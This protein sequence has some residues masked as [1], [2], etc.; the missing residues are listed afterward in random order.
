MVLVPA[1]S[2]SPLS[3]KEQDPYITVLSCWTN[4]EE[5]ESES[6]NE[7]EDKG[8][9]SAASGSDVSVDKDPGS[10]PVTNKCVCGAVFITS[11]N[12]N[13]NNNTDTVLFCLLYCRVSSNQSESERLKPIRPAPPPPNKKPK[14]KIPRFVPMGSEF[15]SKVRFCLRAS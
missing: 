1:E 6:S 7:E 14:Q 2:P 12:H 15:R 4:Q 9:S 5:A 8:V 3:T 10:D 13:D 11:N